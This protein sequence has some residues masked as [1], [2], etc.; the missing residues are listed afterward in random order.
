MC[1][2]YCICFTLFQTS[3]FQV[4]QGFLL[5]VLYAELGFLTIIDRL[6]EASREGSAKDLWGR[7]EPELTALMFTGPQRQSCPIDVPL[8]AVLQWDMNCASLFEVPTLPHSPLFSQQPQQPSNKS[9]FNRYLL[10]FIDNDHA[11]LFLSQL[12]K[13]NLLTPLI[14]CTRTEGKLINESGK[15]VHINNRIYHLILA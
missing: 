6:R 11:S 2:T 8:V 7:R 1:M 4:L 14:K 15:L 10:H 5:L 13:N 12:Y 3:Q 9:S